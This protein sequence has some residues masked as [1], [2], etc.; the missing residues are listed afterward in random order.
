MKAD[1]RW[2][3]SAATAL[4]AKTFREPLDRTRNN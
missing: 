4:D 3:R 1:P 2:H